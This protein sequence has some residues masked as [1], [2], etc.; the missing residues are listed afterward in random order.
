M[1]S[2]KTKTKLVARFV[3]DV[4]CR[5]GQVDSPPHKLASWICSQT[6]DVAHTCYEVNFPLCCTGPVSSLAKHVPTWRIHHTCLL[7]H[8]TDSRYYSTRGYSDGNVEHSGERKDSLN[9]AQKHAH[10]DGRGYISRTK[11]PS[12]YRPEKNQLFLGRGL[13]WELV[14]QNH[15]G[16]YCT[17]VGGH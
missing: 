3:L 7:C 6:L 17:V 16:Y 10:E 8:Q 5:Q 11:N 4:T 9:L 1:E 15:Q 2:S 14:C 12:K 13:C